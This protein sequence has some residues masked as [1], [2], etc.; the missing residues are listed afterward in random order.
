MPKTRVCPS[1]SKEVSKTDLRCKHCN[2]EL[3]SISAVGKD[4]PPLLSADDEFSELDYQPKKKTGILVPALIILLVLSI[5]VGII[6]LR[7]DDE[8]SESDV[9]D[10][11][12]IETEEPEPEPEVEVEQTEEEPGEQGDTAL[13]PPNYELFEPK[14]YSWLMRRVSDPEVILLSS[15]T[16]DDYDRFF[17]LYNLEE[18]NIIVY[19]IESAT[20]EFITV[21]LGI[22]YS[23]WS[24]RAVFI[25]REG[26]WDFL[27]EEA[28]R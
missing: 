12:V 2:S 6:T 26:K 10:I 16:L 14:L 13:L 25:W 15:E 4:I 5:V 1:C 22:P 28:I 27:R 7:N 23:E 3:Q 20:E 9:P 11:S 18:D 21:M 17:E 19:E 24:L 8:G